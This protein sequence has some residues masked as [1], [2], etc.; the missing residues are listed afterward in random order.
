MPLLLFGCVYSDRTE[1]RVV[2]DGGNVRAE[3]T[4]TNLSP[5]DT[6]ERNFANVLEEWRGE[7]RPR[8]YATVWSIYCKSRRLTVEGGVLVGRESL[9]CDKVETLFTQHYG[10]D[11]SA[12]QVLD[13][14]EE[15]G[16]LLAGEGISTNAPVEHR[17]THTLIWW[18]D[19]LREL[20]V[21][22]A[23]GQPDSIRQKWHLNRF[24]AWKKRHPEV[25][26]TGNVTMNA[27]R[28]R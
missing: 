16:L 9:Y 14:D 21:V 8:W 15:I 1:Y 26:P 23:D 10:S 27:S 18:P 22:L 20:R 28:S 12:V 11:R 2:R 24:L 6:T 3:A 4:Y 13:G 5:G 17:G 25:D 7:S 19:T